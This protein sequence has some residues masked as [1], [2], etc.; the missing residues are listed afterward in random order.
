M[1]PGVPSTNVCRRSVPSQIVCHRSVQE[2]RNRQ[3]AFSEAAPRVHATQ[4]TVNSHPDV[5][6]DTHASP[7][8]SRSAPRPVEP[9]VHSEPSLR[10]NA[11]VAAAAGESE[12]RAPEHLLTTSQDVWPPMDAAAPFTVPA[13]VSRSGDGGFQWLRGVQV[14]TAPGAAAP[15]DASASRARASYSFAAVCP[16]P[17]PDLDNDFADHS[18]ATICKI[19]LNF[20]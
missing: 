9:S 11:A 17:T 19:A 18:K 16:P 20:F 14:P 10:D 8:R 5:A 1:H 13:S 6:G 7:G 2:H 3:R 15:S 12:R 4:H